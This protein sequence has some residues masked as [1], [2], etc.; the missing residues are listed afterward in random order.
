M[1]MGTIPKSIT[2]LAALP[3]SLLLSSHALEAFHSESSLVMLSNTKESASWSWSHLFTD[4]L[5]SKNSCHNGGTRPSR[6]ATVTRSALVAWRSTTCPRRQSSRGGIQILTRDFQI[7][8][9]LRES[10]SVR[11]RKSCCRPGQFFPDNAMQTMFEKMTMT[12]VVASASKQQQ[13]SCWMM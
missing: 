5:F 9:P 6:C 13:D 4:M 8:V 11:A 10:F 2:S 7:N 12:V 3:L 1:S